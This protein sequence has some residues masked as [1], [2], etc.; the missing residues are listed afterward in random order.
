M[1]YFTCNTVLY[2]A[3]S[4]ERISG[5][6][7]SMIIQTLIIVYTKLKL[8]TKN[9]VSVQIYRFSQRYVVFCSFANFLLSANGIPQ[10]SMGK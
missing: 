5:A 9:K 1:F 8:K 10:K 3:T 7:F 4:R 2:S 6:C